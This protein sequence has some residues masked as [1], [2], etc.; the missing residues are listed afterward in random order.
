MLKGW[1]Q[2]S[3]KKG[4][5]ENFHS[6]SLVNFHSVSQFLK[7]YYVLIDVAGFKYVKHLSNMRLNAT[8]SKKS[9]STFF[10]STNSV[11]TQTAN[12]N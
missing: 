8:T 6:V 9:I 4:Q 10:H 12:L 5:V 7:R 2:L 1:M 11:V 3:F